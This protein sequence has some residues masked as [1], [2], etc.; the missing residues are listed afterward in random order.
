[1]WLGREDADDDEELD[2][3]EIEKRQAKAAEALK[4]AVDLH[5][6]TAA[7]QEA[8]RNKLASDKQRTKNLAGS[9]IEKHTPKGS[10]KRMERVWLEA[11]D[12]HYP[13]FSPARWWIPS[14]DSKRPGK[15][16]GLV[17]QLIRMYSVEDVEKY[18]KWA[19]ASWGTIQTRFK[20]VPPVPTIGFLMGFR[21]TLLPE[22]VM[23]NVRE[24][25]E[26]ELRA[27]YAQ[28]PN[29]DVPTE[30][31]VRVKALPGRG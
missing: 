1:V 22:A 16:A 15:E 9:A 12:E 21:E 17:S 31:S 4:G 6:S 7:V 5:K 19:V 26:A 3:N 18:L 14:G 29:E 10:V 24:T 2:V 11:F 8:K 13:D 30:L 23:G 28:H 20:D 27:W 25:V